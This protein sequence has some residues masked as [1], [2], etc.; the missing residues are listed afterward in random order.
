MPLYLANRLKQEVKDININNA[1]HI[2]LGFSEMR[3]VPT[4]SVL[5]FGCCHCANNRSA[6]WCTMWRAACT[7]LCKSWSVIRDGPVHF[8]V[9]SS[10]R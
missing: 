1:A 10:E 8:A 3:N 9:N 4:S 2:V 7:Q 5:V 6:P